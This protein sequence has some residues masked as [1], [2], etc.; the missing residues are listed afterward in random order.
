M[1]VLQGGGKRLALA[2]GDT[3][4]GALHSFRRS[5]HHP[6][7]DFDALTLAV[8]SGV[9]GTNDNRGN[10]PYGLQRTVENNRGRLNL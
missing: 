4:I 5:R 7:T 9:S 1:T 8:Q 2:I 3:G 6:R 10:G